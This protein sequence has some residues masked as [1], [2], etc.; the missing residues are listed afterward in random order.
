MYDMS[1]CKSVYSAA[2][3]I[4]ITRVC[5][6]KHDM[7]VFKL[8]QCNGPWHIRSCART[9]HILGCH[10]NEVKVCKS[11]CNVAYM[12]AAVCRRH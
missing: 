12:A 1:S 10:A 7:S 4:S 11:A 8:L 6:K 2:Y 9:Q 5:R 3:C